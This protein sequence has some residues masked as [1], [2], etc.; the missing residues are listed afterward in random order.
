MCTAMASGREIHRFVLFMEPVVMMVSVSVMK[1]IMGVTV[2]ILLSA[3]IYLIQ[4]KL[5]VV[6]M[7]RVQLMVNVYVM[8]AFILLILLTHVRVCWSVTKPLR[9]T[10]SYAVRME[11]VYSTTMVR[12][13][14]ANVILTIPE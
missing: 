3:M 11:S 5:H 1:D 13:E 6:S 12:L 9:L 14:G 8:L 2:K 7:E 10:S 4:M